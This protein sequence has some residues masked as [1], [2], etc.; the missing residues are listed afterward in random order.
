MK[1]SKQLEQVQHLRPA[2]DDREHDDAEGR[3][4][5]GVLVEVVQDDFRH[6]AALE[7]D[8]DPHAVAVG[9]VAQVGDAF[10]LLVAHQ[11]GDL[12]DQPRLVDLVRD[13][14]DDDRLACRPSSTARTRR[15]RAQL[16]AAAAGRDTPDDA[17]RARR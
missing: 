3:L 6:L 4:Q 16:D 10:D 12:L 2:V 5:R 17:L 13:L 11:L 14:G 8:H 15:L 7:L 9:L 1:C